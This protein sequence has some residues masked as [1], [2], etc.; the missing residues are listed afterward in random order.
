MKKLLIISFDIIRESDPEISLNIDSILA[1]LKSDPHYEKLYSVVNYSINL[2]NI[3]NPKSNEI[4][5]TLE[6]I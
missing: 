2:F 5:S 4:L 1:F 6:L 3:K